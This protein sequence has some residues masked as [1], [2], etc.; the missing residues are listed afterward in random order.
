MGNRV[1]IGVY[2]VCL[3]SGHVLLTQLWDRDPAPGRWTLPGG[4]MEFGE[5]PR[6][7]LVREFYEETG[8]I[9]EVGP[10]VDV[11]AFLPRPDFHVIQIVYEV[12]ARGEPRVIEENGS[13][14]DARWVA[15]ATLDDIPTVDLVD[16]VRRIGAW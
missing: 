3:D 10:V 7:T 14:V 2:G 6:E 12:E 4:G 15:T 11:L 8:L 9:P 5:E 16:H 13:T 1:R